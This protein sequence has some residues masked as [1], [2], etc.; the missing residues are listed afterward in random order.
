[1][2]SGPGIE[3]GQNIAQLPNGNGQVSINNVNVLTNTEYYIQNGSGYDTPY[4]SS[5]EYIQYDG[6][7]TK[8]SA[9]ATIQAGTIYHLTIAIADAGDGSW[10]SGIFLE[11]NSLS[12][13]IQSLPNITK[14]LIKIIDLMGRETSFK[15]N[16]PLIYVY[17]DGTT[18]KVFSVEY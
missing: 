7:T 8:L 14:N 3:E 2:I 5:E 1:M 12:A 17:D 10:D 15:P 9:E 13:S 6:F 11:Q 18:E 4:N 16:T